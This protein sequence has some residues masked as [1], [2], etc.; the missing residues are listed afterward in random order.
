MKHYLHDTGSVLGESAG[1][2]KQSA[3]DA[4]RFPWYITLG[5]PQALDLYNTYYF[6]VVKFNTLD[7]CYA[8]EKMSKKDAQWGARLISRLSSQQ[9]E[10]ALIGAGFSAAEVVLLRD[11]LLVRRFMALRDLGLGAEYTNIEKGPASLSLE[12]TRGEIDGLRE[13]YR[14]NPSRSDEEVAEELVKKGI[15]RQSF[16]HGGCAIECKVNFDPTVDPMPVASYVDE[17]S[18]TQQLEP[19]VDN[20]KL[21]NGT[22]MDVDP[23]L[24]RARLQNGDIVDLHPVLNR[25]RDDRD[26]D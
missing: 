20:Y 19:E 22:L 17:A 3:E 13:R 23:N 5:E 21:V 9:I 11:K 2:V 16:C 6:K 1:I 7:E 18:K 15:I 24:P 25:R 10:Q 14:V 4:D 12:T 26:R 8:F